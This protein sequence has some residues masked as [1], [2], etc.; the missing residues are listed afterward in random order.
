MGLNELLAI[1][2]AL[3]GFEAVKWTVNFYVN[4]R[5]NT[6][7]ENATADSMEDENERQQVDWLEKRLAERDTKIDSIY[8]ELR[9]E[10]SAHL[11]EIHKRYEVELRLKEA[12]MKRCDVRGCQNRVPPS[13]Y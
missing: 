7:K 6:R 8:G 4:R 3:G 9:Q 1:I 10:Q 2:G 5:T 13:D 11:E 12:E